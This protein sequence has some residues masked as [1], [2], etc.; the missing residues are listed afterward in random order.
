MDQM[1]SNHL[2]SLNRPRNTQDLREHRAYR[3]IW[4]TS[5]RKTRDLAT[6][7]LGHLAL[8][9]LPSL[10]LMSSKVGVA[11]AILC[12]NLLESQSLFIKHVLISFKPFLTCL[13]PLKSRMYLQ[14]LWTQVSFNVSE[15]RK[16][17]LVRKS[18]ISWF[19]VVSR[20]A[21][22]NMKKSCF[23]YICHTC[24]NQD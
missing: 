9:F 13:N 2:Q 21:T 14:T 1:S 12:Y 22:V 10:F 20:K 11:A 4:S 24:N 6:W 18:S 8:F 5:R 3:D 7:P 16:V 23:Q 17:S 15:R 19:L